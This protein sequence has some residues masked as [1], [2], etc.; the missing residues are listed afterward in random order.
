MCDS[1][2]ESMKLYHVRSVPQVARPNCGFT[3]RGYLSI[4]VASVAR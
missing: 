3:L 4:F 1:T 2:S